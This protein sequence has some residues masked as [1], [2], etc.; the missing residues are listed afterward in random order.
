MS[1]ATKPTRGRR[2]PVLGAPLEGHPLLPSPRRMTTR[3]CAIVLAG[4]A[5]IMLFAALGAWGVARVTDPGRASLYL[6][7]GLGLMIGCVAAAALC[8]TRFGIL[9]GWVVQLVTLAGALVVPAMF[10]VA[11]ICGGLWIVAL[12]QGRRM[13]DLTRRHLLDNA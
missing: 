11:L 2:G 7:V 12:V 3:L 4:Q 13:D 1:A 8:R 5:P 6:W 10:F 9:L